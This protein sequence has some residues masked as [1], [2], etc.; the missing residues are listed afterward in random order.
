MISTETE[1]YAVVLFRN[2]VINPYMPKTFFIQN[3]NYS[4]QIYPYFLNTLLLSISAII[5]VISMF[6][7]VKIFFYFFLKC[8]YFV[9]CNFYLFSNPRPFFNPPISP[10]IW[11]SHKTDS[12]I[13]L[14]RLGISRVFVR[15]EILTQYFS[16]QNTNT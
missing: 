5:K 1:L 8:F 11:N 14:T 7:K 3:P 15:K 13:I 4:G 6:L 12:Q 16:R 2:T 9:F 10:T